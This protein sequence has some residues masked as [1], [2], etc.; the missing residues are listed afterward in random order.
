MTQIEALDPISLLMVILCLLVMY[1]AGSG[2]ARLH[3]R[4][5]R[6]TGKRMRSSQSAGGKA[7]SQ[8]GALLGWYFLTF[9]A[10]SAS[11]FAQVY[12]ANEIHQVLKSVLQGNWPSV[13]FYIAFVVLTILQV[14]FGFGLIVRFYRDNRQSAYEYVGHEKLICI[15][16][17]ALYTVL[18]ICSF[19]Y[20]V[21]YI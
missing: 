2:A 11:H 3:R 15:C 13:V 17:T 16:S 1:L 4:Y 5:L 7:L 14:I 21:F 10:A 6:S 19:W 8:I 9:G 18:Y 20:A 12:S